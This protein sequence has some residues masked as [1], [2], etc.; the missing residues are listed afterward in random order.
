MKKNILLAVLTAIIYGFLPISVIAS[1]DHREQSMLSY[2]ASPTI[3]SDTMR[4]FVLLP[5]TIDDSR[6][7][8]IFEPYGEISSAH[9]TLD[10]A[11][12]KS[13]GFGI[14]TMP[15]AEEARRAISEL[16]HTELDGRTILVK[17]ADHPGHTPNDVRGNSGR[18]GGGD[19]R[20]AGGRRYE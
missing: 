14:V 15:N 5:F 20:G 4:I 11:T 12:G 3:L 2:P 9:I 19:N 8:E 18:G 6:L 17:D 16:N 1:P 10:R 13:R 7:R